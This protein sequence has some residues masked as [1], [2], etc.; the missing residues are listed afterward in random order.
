MKTLLTHSLAATCLFLI[1]KLPAQ[2]QCNFNIAANQY[3]VHVEL[4]A[5]SVVPNQQSC[6]WGYN[7]NLEI[8]YAVSFSGNNP[9]A[10]LNTLQGTFGCGNNSHFFNLPNSGG[11]GTIISQSNQ[12]RSQSDCGTATPESV[13]CTTLSLQINGPGMSNQTVTCELEFAPVPPGVNTTAFTGSYCQGEAFNVA[14]TTSGSFNAENNFIAQLSDAEGNFTNPV[15]IGTESSTT[16]GGIACTLPTAMHSGN[17]Y[18]IR[19]VSTHPA[20]T[21]S[22]NG[23]NLNISGNANHPDGFGDG[24]WHAYCYNINT[25]TSNV[26]NFN[27]S[28]YRGMYTASGLNVNST[29][30]WNQNGNPSQA[31]TYEGCSVTNDRHIV[32]YKRKGF[33]CGQYTLH[34]RGPNN[35]N[36]HDDAAL[37]RINGELVWSNSGCCTAHSSIWSGALDA[38]SEIEFTWSENGGASYGRLSFDFSPASALPLATSPNVTIC[39]GS[40][41]TLTVDQEGLSAIDWSGNST[42]VSGDLQSASLTVSPPAGTPPGTQTYTATAVDASSG[43]TRSGEVVVTIN[44]NFTTNI[45]ENNPQNCS[46][47]GIEAIASGADSYTWSPSEGVVINSSSGHHV[48]LAP[49]ETT[50]YTVTGS[51]NCTTST[52]SITVEGGV[53]AGTEGSFGHQEWRVHCY[54][55]ETYTSDPNQFNYDNYRGMYVHEGLNFDSEDYW[56]TL[57]SPDQADG[58]VGCSVQTNQ[59]IVSYRRR[60]FACGTYRIH[61]RGDGNTPGHDDAAELVI[62]GEQVWQNTGCCTAIDNVWTGVLDA[63]SEVTFTWSENNGNS[64]GRM[65]VEPISVIEPEIT[66]DSTIF[67]GTNTTLTASLQGAVQ[68]DWSTNTTYLEPPFNAGT[69]VVA[70]PANTVESTQVYTVVIADPISACN[71]IVEVPLAILRSEYTWRGTQSDE[72]SFASN[73]L[74][75]EVPP[76]GANITIDTDNHHPLLTGT[77]QVNHLLIEPGSQIDFDNGFATLKV[78]GNFVNNGSFSP[79]RGKITFNGASLQQI[80]GENT[81]IFHSLRLDVS[82]TV[83]LEVDLHLTGA[84]QPRQGVLDWNGHEVWLLSN[85]ENTGSIGEI[86][87]NATLLGNQIRYHRFVPTASANW[88]M[89]CAPLTDITFEQWNDDFPTTGFPGSDFPAWPNTANPWASIRSYDESITGNDMHSGFEPIEHITD[90]ITNGVG[91]FTY[92]AP[93]AT[94]IDMEGTFKRGSQFWEL[95]HTDSNDDPYQDGWNLLG[96]PFP[97]AIDWDSQLGWTKSGIANAIYA[98]NPITGQYTSYINGIGIGE[99]DGKVASS[100][101]FWVKAEGPNASV[102]INERAKVDEQGSFL[103]SASNDTRSIIR[104]RLTTSN[105]NVWDETVIGIHNGATEGFD[106][107]LDAWKF[108]AGNANLPNL[109]SLPTDEGTRALSISMLPLPEEDV[110]VDLVVRKGNYTEFSL[111]NTLVDS[112]DD[113]LCL[114][115][116]DRETG[117]KVSFNQNDSYHFTP[118]DL[119]LET[120]FAL[121][122]SAP[123]EVIVFDESCQNADD[124]KLIAQ[125]FGEAPWS[126]TWFDEMDQVIRTTASSTVADVF[127]NLTPGFYSVRVE[128][129]GQHCNSIEKVVQVHAAPEHLLS[130]DAQRSTCNANDAALSIQ[131][132]AYYSYTISAQSANSDD[133]LTFYEIQGDTL[134]SGLPAG[135]Y[136]LSALSSCGNDITLNTVDLNDPHTVEAGVDAINT[137]VSL[138]AGGAVN[139]MNLSSSNANAFTW[140]F[141]DGAIDSASYQP[142]HTYDHLGVFTVTLIA[143]NTRC[144]DTT[145]LHIHITNNAPSMNGFAAN[146][147]QHGA[148]D[149][150]KIALTNELN[151][152]VYAERM[153]ISCDVTIDEKVM[154]TIFNLAGQ[155][156]LSEELNQLNQGQTEIDVSSLQ[157]GLYTYGLQTENALLKSGEFL[158]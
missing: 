3:T 145:S 19:V 158:K 114:V 27:Y 55:I 75:N 26:N 35:S 109:A 56:P 16:S 105:E 146:E 72:W 13:G 36:G 82:D 93:N 24:I 22:D 110:V 68:Y 84:L 67:V 118:G 121:H 128:N 108:F 92:F 133:P 25:Y 18:R 29:D 156:V 134:L 144:A 76:A 95:S 15:V 152:S 104:L 52:A 99:F 102:S 155:Q 89:L 63:E 124:G 78:S 147:T 70:P 32:R 4:T 23:S 103:K 116:E 42:F 87:A 65:H 113:D 71:H 10:S 59:H 131:T 143:K 140:D 66:A 45:T 5:V 137:S 90:T 46:V 122:I 39:A 94:M 40:E 139:F 50:T 53:G 80:S 119:E 47:S 58:Y 62:N 138:I 14:Y 30:D 51:N 154:V 57:G 127:D 54:N 85:S 148:F 60:G 74:Q 115:L 136:T 64:Y 49:L 33:D 106:D 91:F 38:G 61:L 86:K 142:V 11:T 37:L 100:Q 153:R 132:D 141:G 123:L 120:R 83:R 101:A 81:P 135:W 34:V 129:N 117:E 8:D 77:H 98:Y 2:S 96:N 20:L 28:N 41:T 112:Y 73:W 12:W 97:S 1:F 44:A 31:A 9:P 111:T 150:E 79:D 69:V 48:L 151:I 7:Y 88:R 43:C 107:H 17:G 157:Q 130:V 6:Q 149:N 126:F 21:G 125:G